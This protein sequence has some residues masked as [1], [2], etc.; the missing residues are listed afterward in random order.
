MKKFIITVLLAL[1]AIL[2]GQTTTENYVK[3]TTYLVP[4]QDGEQ[5]N[6][7]TLQKIENVS[8]FDGLGRPTQSVAQRAGSDTQ[9]II[10][11]QEYDGFGRSPKQYLPLPIPSANGA[12]RTGNIQNEINTY[13]SAKYP[14]DAISAG[15]INAYSETRFENS[16]DSRPIEQGSPGADW[17]INPTADTD[18]TIKTEYGANTKSNANETGDDVA[19]FNVDYTGNDLLNPS[20]VYGGVFEANLLR[21]SIVKDENWIPTSGKDHTTETFTN[22]RGQLVLKRNYTDGVSLDTYYVYDRFNN[23]SYVLSPE[24][25]AAILNGSTVTITSQKLEQWCYQYIYDYRNR[26]IK[27][28]VPGKG[29]EYIV[30]DKLDRP[31]MVQD[32]RMRLNDQ[33]LFTKYDVFG[34]P[35]YTG[36]YEPSAGGSDLTS[37]QNTVNA[38]SNLNESRTSFSSTTG[39]GSVYYTN[40]VFPTNDI[41]LHSVSYFDAYT[42]EALTILPSSVY[43]ENII[44]TVKSLPT[45]SKVRVLGTTDWIT[46]VTGYDYKRRPIFGVTENTYL[47]TNDTSESLLDFTGKVLESRTIHQKTNQPTIVTKDYFTYDHQ[48]RLL[49][50]MQQIDDEPVQLISNNI[51]DE[52]GQLVTKDVGGQLFE[53]G[54]TDITPNR[55][56]ISGDGVIKKIAGG[57]AYDAGLATIGKIEGNGGISFKTKTENTRHLVGLNNL[58]TTGGSGDIDYR[59][60]F[61]W[62]NP[63]RYRVEVRENGGTTNPITSPIIYSAGDTF[64]IERED[65]VLHFIHNGAEVATYTM[66]ENYSS[67][68]GDVSMRDVGGEISNLNL[69]ATTINKRLQKVDY[70]YNIRGWMTDINNINDQ[71]RDTKLFNFRINYNQAI[72]GSSSGQGVTPLYNG[73]ISQTTWKTLSADPDTQKRSYGYQYDALNRLE[74]AYSYKGATLT[75]LDKYGLQ[76]IDYDKNGNINTLLRYGYTANTTEVMDQLVYNYLGNQLQNVTDLSTDSIENEGFYD[77]NT[78][79]NDD[80][81]YDVNGNM[82]IDRNKGI[83]NITYNHLNLPIVV[84][85]NTPDDGQGQTQQGS[86]QYVYDATGVKL[87]KQVTKQSQ[88]IVFTRYAGGYIY[89]LANGAEELKMFAHP[90]GYVEPVANTTK[91][92]EKF[93]TQSGTS[94]YS[95]YQYVFNYTDHLGNVR[96]TY[97][98]SDGNGAIEPK[99]EVISEKHYYPFG[100]KHKGYNNTVTSNSNSMAEKFAFGGKELGEEL[101]L[102]W[103]DISARNYDPALGRWMNIDP[104]AEQMRRHSPYNYAFDNPVYFIDPDGLSPTGTLMNGGTISQADVQNSA[105]GGNQ[106]SGGAPSLISGE[107]G[108]VLVNDL[109]QASGGSGSA[110]SSASSTGNSSGTSAANFEKFFNETAESLESDRDDD[111]QNE[112]RPVEITITNTIVGEGIVKPYPDS[113]GEEYVVPLYRMTVTGEDENGQTQSYNFDV[114]RYGVERNESRNSGP[115]VVGLSDAQ[116]YSIIWDPGTMGGEGSWRVTGNWLIHRGAADPTTQAWGAIG[117]IEVCGLNAWDNFNNAIRTLSGSNSLSTIGNSGTLTVT[118]QSA[119]SPALRRRRRNNNHN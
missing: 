41:T 86:I 7:Q 68:V 113:D 93:N 57:D 71:S 49:T 13:Y 6:V 35:I 30:Y 15:V 46:T 31:V 47:N 66:T 61:Y 58:N 69:Y 81:E 88:P 79:Q 76:G 9:D 119:Q 118:Y 92:I 4:V 80:Y 107:T 97:A 108:A 110:S 11:I 59:I 105:F 89:E 17:L 14:Q 2:V 62:N 111:N 10:T 38:Q 112:I 91:S 63:P 83:S 109:T 32:A 100:L 37:V 28:R 12:Y 85:I 39:G 98:D 54:Y 40:V 78:T 55:I 52:I 20:L 50:H 33:W 56:D 21:K 53:S 77:G 45:E 82:I 117:C 72:E 29:W 99:T 25:S 116:S 5:A 16:W 43:N 74:A 24:G 103:Y 84:T 102:D 19:I 44:T 70:T 1:P 96:L 42:T 67:L 106:I 22:D 90:E 101:G 115:R 60:G 26:P 27:K 48:Q 3:N 65:D 64:A 8:Y 34:R 94:S 23:L 73:N 104:L 75:Q 87:E 18:H 114:L 36:L 95:S 51:Y